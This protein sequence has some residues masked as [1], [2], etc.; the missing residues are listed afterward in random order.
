MHQQGSW[1]VHSLLKSETIL[2]PCN[3]SL[4]PR[5]RCKP[6]GHSI[7]FP[8]SIYRI[9]PSIKKLRESSLYLIY[10]IWD[11]GKA[12]PFPT[13]NIENF[14]HNL[15]GFKVTSLFLRNPPY[16]SFSTSPPHF[17]LG[18]VSYKRLGEHRWG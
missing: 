6:V 14:F 18:E 1:C 10:R 17:Y 5:R 3:T 12:P 13:S 11:L 16:T 15:L 9:F 4:V 8:N 7:T 2:S